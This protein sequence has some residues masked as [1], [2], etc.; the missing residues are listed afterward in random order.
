MIFRQDCIFLPE[1]F[2]MRAARA[3]GGHIPEGKNFVVY[4]PRSCAG[5]DNPEQEPR[6]E[7]VDEETAFA[8]W[9]DGDPLPSYQDDITSYNLISPI[10]E[11]MHEVRENPKDWPSSFPSHP[12][13]GLPSIV[14]VPRSW[15]ASVA[16]GNE[17]QGN[18]R[19]ND[20][21]D[22]DD[23]SDEETVEKERPPRP[24][25]NVRTELPTK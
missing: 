19:N 12:S 15:G 25:R 18:E 13:F 23:K 7:F 8:A 5:K 24:R 11:T 14:P 17:H 4:R 9:K 21:E 20:V 6:G 3:K 10:D 22:G 1:V 16:L 2:P